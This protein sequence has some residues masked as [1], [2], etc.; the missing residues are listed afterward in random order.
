MGRASTAVISGGGA[1]CPCRPGTVVIETAQLYQLVPLVKHKPIA[2][3]PSNPT[4]SRRSV[5]GCPAAGTGS[6]RSVVR[7][8]DARRMRRA[9]RCVHA[10]P[11][12][13]LMIHVPILIITIKYHQISRT[14]SCKCAPVVCVGMECGTMDVQP[15]LRGGL[16]TDRMA[17]QVWSLPRTGM[18]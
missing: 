15:P 11:N 13:I 17:T 2:D 7:A 9:G 8:T 12:N 4:H 18:A 6:W 3:S 1:A 14:R 10:S 16:R 5:R